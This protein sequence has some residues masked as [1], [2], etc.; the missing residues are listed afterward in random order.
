MRR[1][2]GASYPF[3]HINPGGKEVYK[4]KTRS[5]AL[6]GVYAAL[7]AVLVVV[8]QPISFSALQFRVAGVLRP[9]IARRR[10]LA[11]AYA[12][13]VLAANFFSPFA[14][15]YELVFMPLMSLVA[16]VA[17]HEAAK[18]LGGGYYTCGV[19]VAVI[20]PLSVAWML[21]QLLGLPVVVTLPGL[22][23]SE[24]LVNLLGATIFREVDKRSRWWEF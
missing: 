10:E 20:I 24:Q 19:V 22:L 23:V 18:R 12:A 14:G 13:G 4:S 6:M 9:A 1:V 17:G 15:G 2:S 5:L 11:L 3:R 8:F 21:N 16:G 7:Y